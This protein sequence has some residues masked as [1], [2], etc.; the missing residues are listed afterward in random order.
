MS[1]YQSNQPGWGTPQA[2]PRLTSNTG[3][4]DYVNPFQGVY[5]ERIQQQFQ[6]NRLTDDRVQRN[7]E[8]QLFRGNNNINLT[9]TSRETEEKNT[10][11]ILELIN[12]PVLENRSEG[13]LTL[14]VFLWQH[15]SVCNFAEND[16]PT[17]V[18]DKLKMKST[19]IYRLDDGGEVEATE[20]EGVVANI[21]FPLE[22]LWVANLASP[23]AVLS[24]RGASPIEDFI[25]KIEGSPNSKAKIKNLSQKLSKTHP[26]SKLYKLVD[27][28]QEG[29]TDCFDFSVHL[30]QDESDKM[31][32]TKI[33]GGEL[34]EEPIDIE[35][36]FLQQPELHRSG[37][38]PRNYQSGNKVMFSD[39]IKQTVSEVAAANYG[40]LRRA[41]RDTF[42][43]V[44]TLG[45]T[46]ILFINA[47]CQAMNDTRISPP[48]AIDSMGDFSGRLD[49]RVNPLYIVRGGRK[50]RSRRKKR[51]DIRK[52]KKKTNKSR[53][54]T[55]RKKRKK[56][57]QRKKNTRKKWELRGGKCTD[58]RG[59]IF[60]DYLKRDY[61]RC[62]KNNN[63][64]N[65]ISKTYC[66]AAA[67]KSRADFRNRK[68]QRRDDE[69]VKR[70][71]EEEKGYLRDKRTRELRRIT[72]FHQQQNYD[73]AQTKRSMRLWYEWEEKDK[74][75]FY[76]S[77]KEE[78]L[79]LLKKQKKGLITQQ[80]T[81]F[82]NGGIE[83]Q[84]KIIVKQTKE[85]INQM[86]D[87]VA[88]NL[89]GWSQGIQ[90]Q[91]N[92][93]KTEQRQSFPRT[94]FEKQQQQ[95]MDP[96]S[97][98]NGLNQELEFLFNQLYNGIDEDI[99][100][101]YAFVKAL[102]EDIKIIK[103]QFQASG[104][105]YIPAPGN[106]L[107][108]QSINLRRMYPTFTQNLNMAF[109][110]Y[111]PS[112]DDDLSAFVAFNSIYPRNNNQS[113]NEHVRA[114]GFAWYRS[115]GKRKTRRKKRKTRKI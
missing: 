13:K 94:T 92:R 40:L 22:N 100:K 82:D 68:K 30:G 5:P 93:W 42:A 85:F 69:N 17:R 27:K 112:D 47:T 28:G 88:T 61:D 50:T 35:S 76:D 39:I 59:Q 41:R 45:I 60:R 53:R 56:R 96:Q 103:R 36:Y 24:S 10:A 54:K 80:R 21:G 73:D 97:Y 62:M 9:P 38:I 90:E 115:G 113:T 1:N 91:K 102:E 37:Q 7:I 86:N 2:L 8:N 72:N 79:E 77:F 109:N 34:D 51:K 19:N 78:R 101:E 67:I 111:P 110:N 4:F 63:Q 12:A 83:A 55:R 48:I 16:T 20:V 98:V 32:L 81:Y 31:G 33:L 106:T 64:N 75:K 58:A 71:E 29:D 89:G 74:K 105:N 104:Q 66:C 3:K 87:F 84:I 43:E 18:T 108:Q 57:K 99:L 46:N 49:R 6:M 114:R 11:D 44:R 26:I 70:W 14:V 95:Q 25:K 65:K 52:R 107:I 23:G 15:G